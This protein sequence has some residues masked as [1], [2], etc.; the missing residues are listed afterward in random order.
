MWWYQPALIWIKYLAAKPAYSVKKGYG[1]DTNAFRR[2]FLDVILDNRL[3]IV[4]I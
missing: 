1:R 3:K 4:K 2:F